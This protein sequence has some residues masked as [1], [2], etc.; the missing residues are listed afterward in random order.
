MPSEVTA[1]QT[2]QGSWKGPNS[3]CQTCPGNLVVASNLSVQ[4][5]DLGDTQSTF[6]KATLTTAGGIR[7]LVLG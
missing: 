1:D 2:R 3:G 4:D 6:V 5:L 7:M